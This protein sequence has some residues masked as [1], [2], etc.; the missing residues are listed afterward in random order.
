[1]MS[2]RKTETKPQK[3]KLQIFSTAFVGEHGFTSWQISGL[4][5]SLGDNENYLGHYKPYFEWLSW[6]VSD[7]L[8]EN[9]LDWD[10]WDNYIA[11]LELCNT[12]TVEDAED[13][14]NLIMKLI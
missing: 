7:V 8:S 12:A 2:N 1:M 4:V 3:T 13:L 10:D 14:K 11:F 9:N 6:A 5:K